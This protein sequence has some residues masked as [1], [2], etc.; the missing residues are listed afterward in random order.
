MHEGP[1]KYFYPVGYISLPNL[2]K[3]I[4]S[5]ASLRRLSSQQFISRGKGEFSILS[6]SP[7]STIFLICL[8]S[9]RLV[10]DDFVKK[11]RDSNKE[12]IKVPLPIPIKV[13]NFKLCLMLLQGPVDIASDGVGCCQPNIIKKLMLFPLKTTYFVAKTVSF[14]PYWMFLQVPEIILPVG[15]F[16]TC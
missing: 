3:V 5:F 1:Q 8:E 2:T 13:T 15:Y 6:K 7:D 10:I 16:Y 9:H 4:Y 12:L 11:I 14:Q